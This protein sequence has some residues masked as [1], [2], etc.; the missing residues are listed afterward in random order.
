M[1][2]ETAKKIPVKIRFNSE[3]EHFCQICEIKI[4]KGEEVRYLPGRIYEHENCYQETEETELSGE[5]DSV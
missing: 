2:E 4:N 3:T 1:V 5:Q